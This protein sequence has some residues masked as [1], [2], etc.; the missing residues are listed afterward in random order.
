LLRRLDDG[1]A[2]ILVDA[3]GGAFERLGRSAIDLGGLELVLIT[4]T[5]IDHSG[6][7]APIVF[8]LYMNERKRPLAVVGPAGRDMHPGCRRFTQLLFGVVGAWSYL[9]TFDG[10]GIEAR[11]VN[12]DANSGAAEEVPAGVALD[13]LGVRVRAVPVPHGMMP[14]AAYRID[15]ARR[16]RL[17]LAVTSPKRRPA[18]SNSRATATFWFT[19]SHCP[20]ATCRIPTFTRNLPRSVVRHV[21]PPHAR[22]SSRISCP[23]SR[24]NS[25]RRSRSF[26]KRFPAGS[27]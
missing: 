9:H 25:S 11:E 8:D 1:R 22:C 10:F 3:G 19:T 16:R 14:S 26:G 6:G 13:A 5:H 20:N 4:H 2:R 15:V 24:T 7:L 12:A 17:P 23:R 18:S 27:W 21:M